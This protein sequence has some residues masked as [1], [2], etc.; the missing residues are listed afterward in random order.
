MASVKRLS[1]ITKCLAALL[2]MASF[3]YDTKGVPN[4]DENSSIAVFQDRNIARMETKLTRKL[5]N[6]M[7]YISKCRSAIILS[8]IN[9]R[10]L[11]YYYIIFSVPGCDCIPGSM[12]NDYCCKIGDGM[13][14]CCNIEGRKFMPEKGGGN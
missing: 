5:S 14:V 9:S 11:Y 8:D 3:P 10:R 7:M 2:A 13:S 1:L 4:N 6:N 12:I